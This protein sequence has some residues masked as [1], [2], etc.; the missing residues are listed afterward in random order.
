LRQEAISSWK[1]LSPKTLDKP[2]S[3]SALLRLVIANLPLAGPTISIPPSVL[4]ARIMEG[5]IGDLV[6]VEAFTAYDLCGNLG[7]AVRQDCIG[8][9]E[10][11]F[12][13]N[14]DHPLAFLAEFV[15]PENCALQVQAWRA[16][17]SPYPDLLDE[18]RVTMT[19]AKTSAHLLFILPR[20]A[21]WP[22]SH[23][24]RE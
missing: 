4:R 23:P 6:H 7:V 21:D 2:R 11:L 3:W 17:D 22:N 14:L 24:S 19:G 20:K 10:K 12:Q 8:Y 9:Q 15:E 16:A 1:N 18:L 5:D 13:N